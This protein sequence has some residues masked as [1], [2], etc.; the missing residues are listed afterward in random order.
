MGFSGA[1]FDGRVYFRPGARG[2]FKSKELKRGA[3]L[4]VNTLILIGASTN[5]YNCNDPTLPKSKRVMEFT[6]LQEAKETLGSGDLLDAVKGAFSPSK[7]QRFAIGPTLIK[8]LNI[9]DNIQA[10]VVKDG[11][12]IKAMVPGTNGNKIRFKVISPTEIVI[13]DGVETYKQSNLVQDDLSIQYTGDS[14][15]A[16]I[17]ITSTNIT[18]TLAGDQT[19]GSLGFDLPVSEYPTL[20]DLVEKISSLTGY[21]VSVKSKPDFL[22]ADLDYI[23]GINIKTLANLKGTFYRQKSFLESTG[24][25]EIENTTNTPFTA[26]AVYVYLAN[27]STGIWTN[28]DYIDAIEFSKNVSGLYRNV[29]TNNIAVAQALSECLNFM[30]S[31]D[32]SSETF[33]GAGCSTALLFEERLDL[34][35]SINNEYMV[36]GISPVKAYGFDGVTEKTFDGWYLA[37]LHNACKA[38]TNP[39]EAISQKA[40]NI[41]ESPEILSHSQAIKAIQTGVLHTKQDDS[42]KSW[43]IEFALTTFQKSDRILTQASYVCTALAMSKDFRESLQIYTSEIVDDG[44]LRVFVDSKLREYETK[45]GYI[46]PN[47]YTG[48]PAADLNYTIERD[49]DI[50]YFIFPDVKLTSPINFFFHIFNLSL[51]KGTSTGA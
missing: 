37:I 20:F 27:G 34:A 16:T 4:D 1:Y 41:I 32:G 25:V 10:E 11:H 38:A 3:S 26:D 21:A 23:T 46:S 6:N 22:T 19:D 13:T 5:G 8:C 49:G 39:R 36:Y 17:T 47:I 51:P 45:F 42:T 50:V 33:G 43:V 18:V 30:N 31:P 7:D 44:D 29:C 40:L 28:T 35:K 2:K 9:A 24:L 12:T 15:T 14:S 48:E